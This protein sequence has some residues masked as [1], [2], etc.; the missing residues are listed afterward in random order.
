MRSS[1]GP[2]SVVFG[3]PG[4]RA[5]GEL[6]IDSEELSPIEAIFSVS[7]SAYDRGAILTL[8]FSQRDRPYRLLHE[9]TQW[10][11]V[12]KNQ[13]QVSP[14]LCNLV[15]GR[16]EDLAREFG[17]DEEFRDDILRAHVTALL[18][19]I[20]RL[21]IDRAQMDATERFDSLTS[22]FF[23]LLQREEGKFHR[24][25]QYSVM[26]SVNLRALVKAVL[27]ETGKSPSAWIRDWTLLESRRLLTYTDL[28]I[29][30]I[31]YRLN[32]RNVSYFVR[33][34][35]RL[36][37]MSPGAARNKAGNRASARSTPAS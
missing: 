10:S 37:G 12:A 16:F 15:R 23:L 19:C 25:S 35:R 4:G 8:L 29:S 32:F 24:A 7:G 13:G 5:F 28:T 22:R 33:F 6:S 26:L 34:Y 11:T 36:T 9:L 18:I 1:A 17:S 20:H 31:A 14:I 3:G 30:E 27:S 21:C 2:S